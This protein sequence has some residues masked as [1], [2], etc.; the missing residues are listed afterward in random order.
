MSST[1]F[2]W[3]ALPVKVGVTADPAAG[4][5]PAAVTVTATKKW[6]L[7]SVYIASMVTDA[8]VASRVAS[9]VITDGTNTQAQFMYNSNQAASLTRQYNWAMGI[10]AAYLANTVINITLP[11]GGLELP[12]GWTF[13]VTF[14]N[15]QAADDCGVVRYSYKEAS[16]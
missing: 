7:T 4:A 5:N 3:D 16:A 13:Q 2:S 12:A 15:I 6:L 14:I 9:L 8:N 1:E 10:G 11:G